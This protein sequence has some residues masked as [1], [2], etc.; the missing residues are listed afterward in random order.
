[1]ARH[2]INVLPRSLFLFLL[3]LFQG[4][5]KSMALQINPN[6]IIVGQQEVLDLLRRESSGNPEEG[7]TTNPTLKGR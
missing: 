2:L 5:R 7:T 3:W 6:P 1:M 4:P